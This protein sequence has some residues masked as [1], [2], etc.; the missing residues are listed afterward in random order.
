MEEKVTDPIF[1]GTNCDSENDS[2]L[3]LIEQ[4]IENQDDILSTVGVSL[5]GSFG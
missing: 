5:V 1:H 4:A 2:S 3:L